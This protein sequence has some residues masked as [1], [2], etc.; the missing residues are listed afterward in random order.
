[1]KK[2]L[3]FSLIITTVLILALGLVP[4]KAA[5]AEGP[6]IVSVSAP[7]EVNPGGQFT[8]DIAVE[9]GAAIAGMQFNITFDASVVTAESVVE[10][11]LLSQGGASTY[12]SP[13]TIDNEAGTISGVAGAITT[14]G[15]S[16]STPG[17]F[18]VIM[19]TAGPQEGT[20]TLN[21]SEVVAGDINGQAVEISVVNGQ[22]IINNSNNN[23]GGSSGGGG[24]GGGSGG[25][26]GGGSTPLTDYMTSYGTLTSEVTAT[27]DESRVKLIIPKGATVKN[28]YGQKVTSI[29][30]KKST[31]SHGTDADSELIS[32][33][34]DIDP[35]GTTF[36]LPATLVFKYKDS[37][38]PDEI[39]E[40]SLYEALW[41]PET[42][43][44]TDLGGTVDPVTHTVSVPIKHL[45][46][47]AL[48]AYTRPVSFEIS[49]FTLSTLQVTPGESI[50]ISAL[51]TNTGDLA[52]SCEVI[53]KIDGAAA[54]EKTV[55]LN[56]RRSETVSF[57]V[58]PTAGE[59]LASIGDLSAGFSV[60]A[61]ATPASFTVSDLVVNPAV[62]NAGDNVN[63][64]THVT[65]NGGLAGT[66]NAVLQ[67]DDTII[68]TRTIELGAGESREVVFTVR[69][70]VA[71]QHIIA[72]GGLQ[73]SLTVQAPSS[74]AVKA[75][76]NPE[77]GIGN[78]R[79]TPIHDNQTGILVATRIEYEL[80][81]PEERTAGTGLNL[82][83]YY[84]GA[85]IEEIPLLSLNNLVA[86]NNSGI[87]D[88]IPSDGWESGVYSFQAE[89]YENEI[90]VQSTESMDVTVT[91]EEIAAVVS[92]KILGIII[93]AAVVL[94]GIVITAVIIRRRDMLHS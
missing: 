12:F 69:P 48:M 29:R 19:M 82:K 86:G 78:L 50:T 56:G 2:T 41:D 3:N 84:E 37:E 81:V 6:T 5:L 67:I 8:I 26:G 34:Y 27:D 54:A 64:S 55:T 72:T 68:E 62:I 43:E 28:R 21:L 11:N 23:G 90:P 13:G 93:G 66:Y 20:S 10:G 16:V 73:E 49:E 76:V 47:Y 15:Q 91:S 59:H 80:Y 33:L 89:L 42:G 63:V 60:K 9:P 94:A 1:M 58:I 30:I 45:S 65:N 39:S 38:I 22:V 40:D 14:P 79:V 92:W 46:V 36:S 52:G 87:L 61:S 53:L 35:E 71:G 83:V 18:A 17:T 70:E 75:P 25:G 24:G 51:V 77:P 32:P 4:F 31:E 7:V 57:S 88:Y 44:W 85:L 74:V